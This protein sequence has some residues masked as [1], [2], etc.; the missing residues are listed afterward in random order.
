MAICL[1]QDHVIRTYSIPI[2]GD[3][4]TK[5]LP[6]WQ[7]PSMASGNGFVIVSVPEDMTPV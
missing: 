5:L 1:Y 7:M 4:P 6:I 3:C 2:A